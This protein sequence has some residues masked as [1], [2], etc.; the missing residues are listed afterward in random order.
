MTSEKIIDAEET[1]VVDNGE[2]T[3]DELD[4]LLSDT[5]SDDEFKTEFVDERMTTVT[6]ARS[7]IM[8]WHQLHQEISQVREGYALAKMWDDDELK[9]RHMEQG[10]PLIKKEK[11][12]NE[13]VRDVLTELKN[14]PFLSQSELVQL[15]KWM[16]KTLN[17]RLE[18]P[19]EE[20]SSLPDSAL[21]Q[22][23]DA[24][25]TSSKSSF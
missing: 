8:Y 14:V 3:D 24:K 16:L 10:R 25:T 5:D 12:L 1:K 17:V 18:D 22:E 4:A 21:V 7:L 20:V 15:P 2:V 19:V 6:R 23:D 11:I 9:T 13:V